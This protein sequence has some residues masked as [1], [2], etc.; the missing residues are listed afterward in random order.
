MG[1]ID[2]DR[3]PRLETRMLHTAILEFLDDEQNRP[4]TTRQVFYN[5]VTRHVV[6]NTEGRYRAITN[7]LVWLRRKGIVPWEWIDDR[8]RIPRWR[9]HMKTIREL[10]EAAGMTQLELAT[11]IGVT[12]ST[13]YN[14]ERGRNEPKA[15]QL[16][17]LARVF[18]VPMD[19][20]DFEV[21][22]VKSV[23]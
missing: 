17:A 20:I 4:A 8:N 6:E 5:L 22:D 13:V 7:E 3:K 9:A 1:A 12:P 11:Q 2:L 23:A 16:R 10:R 14:W 19:V 21:E 15:T 18:G